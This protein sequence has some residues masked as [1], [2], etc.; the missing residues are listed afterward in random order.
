M[1]IVDNVINNINL[2]KSNKLTKLEAK[3]ITKKGS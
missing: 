2:H 1:S 3:N